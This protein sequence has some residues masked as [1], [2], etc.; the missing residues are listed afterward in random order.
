[1][2]IGPICLLLNIV[3]ACMA[4]NKAGQATVMH[5]W[6]FDDGS[7]GG[8]NAPE[9]PVSQRD[10]DEAQKLVTEQVSGLGHDAAP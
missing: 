4:G 10:L 5:H 8:P 3:W 9:V 6:K 1:M 2:H 7:E